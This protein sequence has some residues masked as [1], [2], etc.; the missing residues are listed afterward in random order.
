M[1]KRWHNWSFWAGL[2][3]VLKSQK[4]GLLFEC[5]SYNR[6]IIIR[7]IKSFFDFLLLSSIVKIYPLTLAINVLTSL[8]FWLYRREEI[9]IH[10]NHCSSS[11]YWLPLPSWDVVQL[12]QK[13]LHDVTRPIF[14]QYWKRFQGEESSKSFSGVHLCIKGGCAPITL[15]KN[16]LYNDFDV[17][18]AKGGS[19]MLLLS[20]SWQA[21]LT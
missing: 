4:L 11:L 1:T 17:L 18:Q 8:Y 9:D 21:N 20:I 7:K 3:L 13:L 6:V 2:Y 16:L 10:W 5:D 15:P 14:V 19:F 12:A